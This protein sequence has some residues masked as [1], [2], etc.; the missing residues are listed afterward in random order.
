MGFRQTRNDPLPGEI[1]HRRVG[2]AAEI[3]EVIEVGPFGFA[4]PHVKFRTQLLGHDADSTKVLSVEVFL[5]RY[6]PQADAA[7]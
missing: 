4:L 3:A 2:D 1:Y 5:E 7:A 6:L